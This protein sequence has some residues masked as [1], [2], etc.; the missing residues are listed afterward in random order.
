MPVVARIRG[1]AFRFYSNEGSEPP[2]IH[3][4][5]QGKEAKF[6]LD[7]VELVYNYGYNN[8][9]INE[10]RRLVEDH[11]QAFLEAWDAFF[12]QP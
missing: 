2:H 12:K 9:E 7:P 6:W 5:K 4:H 3:V 10:I 11:R 1:Y 8:T